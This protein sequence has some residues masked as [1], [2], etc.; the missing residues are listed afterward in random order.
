MLKSP[1]IGADA[2]SY[3]AA[4]AAPLAAPTGFAA[5]AKAR[6]NSAVEQIA[7]DGRDRRG[8]SAKGDSPSAAGGTRS[9]SF[10]GQEGRAAAA[11]FGESV[12]R[13]GLS[14]SNRDSL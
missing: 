14:S 10:T 5:T 3:F 1:N 7:P 6:I 13:T 11:A 12:T 4:P 2:E 8:R 9:S